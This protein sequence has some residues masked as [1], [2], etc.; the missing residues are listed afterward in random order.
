VPEPTSLPHLPAL[1]GLRGLAV[2]AVL[3][4]HGDHLTGGFLG[5]DLFFVL[6]GFL[7]TSLLLTEARRG[8]IDI[9]R[10]WSRRARR[11]L[12][13]LAV[14]LCAVAAYAV[15]FARPE[16]LSRIRFDGLATAFYF[17]NWRNVF[18]TQS[19]WDLFI[20]PSPLAHTWSLAIEEQFY[21]VWPLL[22]AGVVAWRTR[23]QR[24]V[25]PAVF[26]LC[27]V[28]GLASLTAM[29]FL[30][31][32]D[33]TNRA[34]FGTDT[35]AASIL[36]GAGLAALLA[37]RGR[38][39]TRAGWRRVHVAAL[40]G[41]VV[42][43]YAWTHVDGTSAT[44]YRGGF[45]VGALA[46]AAIIAG[47]LDAR[48]TLLNRALRFPALVGLGVISYGVYL[49]H[50]PIFVVLDS[51]RTGI[52][53]WP[54]LGVRVGVTV[55]IAIVSYVVI[56][57][58]IRRGAFT[59]VTWRRLTPAMATVVVVAIVASTIRTGTGIPLEDRRPDTPEIAL[60]A[61]AKAPPTT[62]RLLIVGNSVGFS[63]ADG[64]KTLPEEQRPVV[65]NAAF[66]SCVFPSGVTRMRNELEQVSR[67]PIVECAPAWADDVAQFQPDVALLVLGDFGDGA[68]EHDGRWL[69][70][71]TQDFDSWYRES[72]R[73]AVHTLGAP[74]NRVAISTSAY[75]YGLF[76]A[77]RFAK[78]DCVNAIDREVAAETPNTVLVDLASFTCPTKDT[79]RTEQDGVELR[80]DGIHY[81]DD[82]ARLVAS[83]MLPQLTK[84]D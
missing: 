51:T 45:F 77:S 34:Y 32:A 44:V 29:L 8:R 11:L 70:P 84:P 82:S 26:A 6:S 81:V 35:R 38:P 28:L 36:V 10:F 62:K 15:L 66:P 79:C 71:C 13:A 55:A 58:P 60:A 47:T 27:A 56:E 19:Y 65:F 22:I 41:T 3:L 9:V 4:F 42:L 59:A 7:I 37:W 23:A 63:L 33:D 39:Q 78:D 68:Y 25:A 43:A 52:S 75:A 16:E 53:G 12:P 2:A 31:R 50:W 1:D 76:G 80:P 83:W 67:R 30:Y 48:P 14:V 40:A 74:G 72:L 5:V 21:V 46:A 64:F 17:A 61:A 69:E 54:L 24:A 18:E 73:T 57:H 20:R 49:W